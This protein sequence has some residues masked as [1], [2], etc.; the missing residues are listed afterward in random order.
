MDFE[1]GTSVSATAVVW[2]VFLLVIWRLHK[3]LV[4]Y[5]GITTFS[6]FLPYVMATNGLLVPIANDIA[7]EMTGID[8]TQLTSYDDYWRSL[9]VMYVAL[10]A[11]IALAN[12]FRRTPPMATPVLDDLQTSS[13]PAAANAYIALAAVIAVFSVI[14]IYA[15]GFGFDVLSWVTLQMDYNAYNAHRQ[16]FSEASK[17]WEFYVYNKLLYAI[18]PLALVLVS[19]MRGIVTW[20]RVAFTAALALAAMQS[21]HKMPILFIIVL[22][23]FSKAMIRR[24]LVLE[25]RTVVLGLALL[26][27][28]T[29]LILPGFYLASGNET[30]VDSLSWSFERL[31][32]EQ[33]RTLLLHFET[34]PRLH[35]FLN[36]ASTGTI[37]TLMGVTDYVP[38]SVF[39]PKNMGI[40]DTSFVALFIGEAWADF[41]FIG[42]AIMSVVVGFMLQ[43]YNI[44]FYSQQ[45]PHLE[46]TATFLVIVFNAYHLLE[47]NF[48]T[49]LFTYGLASTFVIYLCIRRRRAT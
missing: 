12:R 34:Y 20:K 36:G 41:G 6:I 38:P 17:G 39:I 1:P 7:F 27:V 35:P 28:L 9:A 31:F 21:G 42:V 37:A 47:C 14:Q 18:A 19:N 10:L 16:A 48:F 3:R 29:F 43:L 32:L 4:G 2:W 33:E 49:T 23:I 44:W 46:E 22:I 11:G 26:L 8:L 40:D 15:S 24:N 25:R 30:Y 5:R 13:N 45:R